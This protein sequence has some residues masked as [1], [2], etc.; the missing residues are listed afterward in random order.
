MQWIATPRRGARRHGRRQ[1]AGFTLYE[2]IIVL[3]IVTITVGFAVPAFDRLGHRTEARGEFALMLTAI[4]RARALAVDTASRVVVCPASD[5]GTACREEPH[6][7]RG[8]IVFGDDDHDRERAPQET[9]FERGLALTSGNTITSSKYRR[10]IGFMPTGTAFGSNVTL[11]FCPADPR[12]KP[13]AII[14][15]NVGRPR[16]EQLPDS[17]CADAG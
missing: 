14:I 3:A 8:W 11:R 6:W 2:A 5:D 13:R 15:S 9:I 1:Q 4:N 16:T 17:A 10:R 12:L 7:H